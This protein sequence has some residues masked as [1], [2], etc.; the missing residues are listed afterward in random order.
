MAGR[1]AGKPFDEP[2]GGAWII[3]GPNTTFMSLSLKLNKNKLTFDEKGD[4]AI[5]LVLFKN[6]RKEEGSKAPDYRAYFSRPYKKDSDQQR[7]GSSTLQKPAP[8]GDD[9]P[10]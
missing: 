9:A 6:Y 5:A 7:G 4:A 2:I 1:P 3:K 8:E 10:F